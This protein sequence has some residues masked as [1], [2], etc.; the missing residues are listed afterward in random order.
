[1]PTQ[2]MVI[3]DWF[4]LTAINWFYFLRIIMREL[5]MALYIIGGVE[6]KR[7]LLLGIH[8]QLFLKHWMLLLLVNILVLHWL[9]RQK[10]TS[11]L[12]IRTVIVLLLKNGMAQIVPITTI[13]DR[14]F[15]L[16]IPMPE[17]PMQTMFIRLKRR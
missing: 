14:N 2:L 10:L 13:A 12:L 9:E 1:M 4:I 8:L 3:T 16:K 17:Q 5:L 7:D 15:S 11:L 6:T